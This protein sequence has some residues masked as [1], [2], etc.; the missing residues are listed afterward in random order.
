LPQFAPLRRECRTASAEPVCSCALFFVHLAHETVGAARTRRSL[1][2]LIERDNVQTSGIRA[3]RIRRC[4]HWSEGISIAWA[5]IA[6]MYSVSSRRGPDPYP[7]MSIVALCRSSNPVH[8][9]HWWVL[10]FAG[11]T[12]RRAKHSS[13]AARWIA[14]WSLSSGAHSRDPLAR[15]TGE[16]RATFSASSPANAR[17]P[18]RRGFPGSSAEASGTLDRRSSRATGSG[19]NDER[20]AHSRDLL[21]D[22]DRK[23]LCEVA[24][25]VAVS[26]IFGSPARLKPWDG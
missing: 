9:I 22:N 7:R 19:C 25:S 17:R 3:A 12:R 24:G 6:A 11:T 23:G 15:M 1:L 4:V 5:E 8:Q 16:E 18:V 21:A 10:A 26:G 14:S 20:S 13:C 2:P